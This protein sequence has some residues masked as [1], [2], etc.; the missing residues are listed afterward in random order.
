MVTQRSSKLCAV[1]RVYGLVVNDMQECTALYSITLGSD[2][3]CR[4]G[5]SLSLK[6]KKKKRN[7]RT[8][9]INH[10]ITVFSH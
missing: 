3:I 7:A 4:Q 10:I 9:C 2:F 8:K 1:W 5:F 6:K